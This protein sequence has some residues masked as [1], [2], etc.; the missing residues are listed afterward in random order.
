MSAIAFQTHR[1]I[2][3]RQISCP[4]MLI[5][6]LFA[7]LSITLTAQTDVSIAT[8]NRQAIIREGAGATFLQTGLL[9]AFIEV[10]I[11]ERNRIG[12]WLYI[13]SDIENEAGDLVA[14]WTTTG[15]LDLPDDLQFSDVPVNTDIADADN[16]EATYISEDLAR[17]YT[18]PILPEVNQ[19]M[20][21]VY[22]VGQTLGNQANVMVKVGDSN[23]VSGLYLS[24]ITEG[25]YDLGAYDF[26]QETVD[27][28]ADSFDNRSV[29]A[30]V[31]LN[32]FSVFDPIWAFNTCEAN[33]SPLVCEYRLS[34]PSV[35]V[36]M[37]G[38]ND[39]RVLNSEDFEA[40]T[41]QIVETSLEFG[42][43]PL[44]VTFTNNPELDDYIWNQGVRFNLITA[45][46]ADEYQ[47][48][49]LNFWIPAQELPNYGIGT[50]NV[51]L[52]SSG[53]T[54]AFNG[55]ESRFGT[56]LHNLLVLE[57][58]DIIRQAVEMDD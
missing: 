37:F 15:G 18:V 3:L 33:E 50:D 48:P 57:A 8:T 4:V 12:N 6:V 29:A 34:R 24:P 10:R 43:I 20:I 30:Q 40:Q 46:I 54:V 35:A 45:D 49:L 32:A 41:R 22:Q 58:L 44:L 19:R 11:I 1:K 16:T 23:S 14:G 39:T 25:D 28:F 55:Y 21:G 52:T 56:T 42:V 31:G 7:S 2:I 26:L 51:H 17:L 36:I 38:Q 27:F 9:P 5:I 13:E 53:T 47:V